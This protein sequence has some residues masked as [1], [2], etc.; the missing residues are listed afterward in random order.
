[1]LYIKDEN[2]TAYSLISH[3]VS[4]R[5]IL[6]E[7]TINRKLNEDEIDEIIGYAMRASLSLLGI[8]ADGFNGQHVDEM[9]ASAEPGQTA[10]FASGYPSNSDVPDIA[11]GIMLESPGNRAD[12]IDQKNVR[13]NF[14]I[15][16]SLRE[17]S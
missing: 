5:R 17:A 10:L 14:V 13:R 7:A 9:L 3:R 4:S 1:M 6:V 2:M 15:Q 8:S 16:K 11:Y 12:F